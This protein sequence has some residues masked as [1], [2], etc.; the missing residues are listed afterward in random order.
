MS[1]DLMERRLEL[2]AKLQHDLKVE[3]KRGQPA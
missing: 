1:P 3:R 2:I